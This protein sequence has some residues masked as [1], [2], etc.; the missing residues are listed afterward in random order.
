MLWGGRVGN[1]TYAA[2]PF[3][4]LT[5]CAHRDM[6]TDCTQLEELSLQLCFQSDLSHFPSLP[7]VRKL[8]LGVVQ[9]SAPFF[10]DMKKQT[11][12]R[13]GRKM[14]NLE[15][16]TWIAS[17]S[18]QLDGPD[19]QALSE[20]VKLPKLKKL[21][22]GLPSWKLEEDDFYDLRPLVEC[23]KLTSIHLHL[24]LAPDQAPVYLDVSVLADCPNL[25][26]LTVEVT[27]KN[28]GVKD[29]SMFSA[30]VSIVVV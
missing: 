28:G 12:E 4:R 26:D 1:F 18:P 16:L 5:D 23:T 14:E 29:V 13:V 30:N 15:D 25:R 7:M 9:T 17:G 21:K 27:N 10:C 2:Q 22:V 11:F 24:F 6:L 19:P 20:I 3:D 8:N